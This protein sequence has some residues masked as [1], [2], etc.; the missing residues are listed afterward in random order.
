MKFSADVVSERTSADRGVSQM[1][2]DIDTQQRQR[3]S[4]M[5]NVEYGGANGTSTTSPSIIATTNRSFVHDIDVKKNQV[6]L[7]PYAEYLMCKYK[8][9]V[10]L[11]RTEISKTPPHR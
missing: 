5:F 8:A 11:I 9:N 4:G 1:S 2:S 6:S 10:R 3:V 7:S